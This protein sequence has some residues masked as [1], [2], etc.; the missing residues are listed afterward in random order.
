MKGGNLAQINKLD[1]IDIKEAK[2]SK[3]RTSKRKKILNKFLWWSWR[4][5]SK[6][7]TVNNEETIAI[8]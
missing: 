7:N 6:W 5:K 1:P 3:E 2:G 8:K 4:N